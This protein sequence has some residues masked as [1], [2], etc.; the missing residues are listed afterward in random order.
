MSFSLT[1]TTLVCCGFNLAQQCRMV[2]ST[3]SRYRLVGANNI[4]LFD[5]AFPKYEGSRYGRILEDVSFVNMVGMPP[6]RKDTSRS[7]PAVLLSQLIVICDASCYS[8][9]RPHKL[10]RQANHVLRKTTAN[11]Q[12]RAIR[13]DGC[14]H[15][16]VTCHLSSSH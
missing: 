13:C 12:T 5:N 4:L 6:C 1:P 2:A 3:F 14:K 8:Q 15:T 10:G 9:I 16:Q 7:R 11:T